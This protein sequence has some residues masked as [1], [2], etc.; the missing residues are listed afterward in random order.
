M[1]SCIF[2][3]F[4]H[5][6]S[7]Y[8]LVASVISHI[9][10]KNKAHAE[11]LRPATQTASKEP[12]FGVT[13]SSPPIT[14]SEP[15]KPLLKR[16][17]LRTWSVIR[18]IFCVLLCPPHWC[19]RR[20]ASEPVLSGLSVRSAQLLKKPLH[21]LAQ[22]PLYTLFLHS[23]ALHS[24]RTTFLNHY[25]SSSRRPESWPLVSFQLEV[26][27]SHLTSRSRRSES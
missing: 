18:S 6:S 7:G 12:I 5:F 4:D 17:A 25:F 9:Q 13:I 24:T 15:T 20:K 19:S 3:F 21:P 2:S 22:K 14:T 23:W 8:T 11:T 10:F 27:L 26:L 1:V 16:L